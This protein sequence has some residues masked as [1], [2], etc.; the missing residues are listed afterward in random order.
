MFYMMS[1]YIMYTECILYIEDTTR[2]P[3]PHRHPHRLHRQACRGSNR[4]GA[5]RA[6]DLQLPCRSTELGRLRTL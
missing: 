3:D 6:I 2:R 1:I 5:R 4:K